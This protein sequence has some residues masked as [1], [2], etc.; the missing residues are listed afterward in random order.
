MEGSEFF[1][2]AKLDDDPRRRS[3]RSAQLVGSLRFAL[4]KAT[5]GK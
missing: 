2:R 3:R 4:L 5:R 1:L